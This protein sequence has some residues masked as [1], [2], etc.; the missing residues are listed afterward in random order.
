MFDPKTKV[1][2]VDDMSTMRKIVIKIVK[3][4]GFTDIHEAAD[5][6]EAWKH[7]SNP[8]ETNFGLVISDWNMPNCTGLEFLKR[9]RADQRYSK[10]P[11]I[12]VTAEAEGHQVA[13]AVKS[14]VDQYVVKPF[15]RDSLKEKLEAVHKK[16]NKAA[17]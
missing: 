7:I 16:Y 3:D 14:G 12:L 17:A 5:G 6:N 11:F 8:G 9:L 1:L 13:E 10:T 2:V 15:S 4:L